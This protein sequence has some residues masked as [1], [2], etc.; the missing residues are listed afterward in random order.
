MSAGGPFNPFAGFAPIAGEE[1]MAPPPRDL[2]PRMRKYL[3]RQPRGVGL[4][5]SIVLFVLVLP[6]VLM[7]LLISPQSREAVRPSTFVQP[8]LFLGLVIFFYARVRQRR[9]E[10]SRILVDG[11]AVL[12]P[13]LTAHL[14]RYRVYFMPVGTIMRATFSVNGRDVKHRSGDSTLDDL[15]PGMT[16]SVLQH[17]DHPDVV[18]PVQSVA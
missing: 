3:K 18:V 12:A 9:A 1:P 14:T 6:G 8:A 10:I 17:P 11:T 5:V 7:M 2:T 16:I 15:E 4:V 13:V